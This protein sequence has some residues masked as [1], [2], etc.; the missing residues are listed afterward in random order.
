MKP[1]RRPKLKVS[2]RNPRKRPKEGDVRAQIAKPLGTAP[3][4]VTII[5]GN[6]DS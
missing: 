5:D 2:H 3:P 6:T 4:V 1:R